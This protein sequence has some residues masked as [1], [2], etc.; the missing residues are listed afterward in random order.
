M[1]S[2]MLIKTKVVEFMI[3]FTKNEYEYNSETDSPI[4][5][6]A[7]LSGIIAMLKGHY[8]ITIEKFKKKRSKNANAYMWQ[9]CNKIAQALSKDGEYIYTKEE[10]YRKAIREVGKFKD[11]PFAEVDKTL[12]YG[13]SKIG[14]GYFTEELEVGYRMYY[15]SSSYDVPQ[16]SRLIDYV[17]QDAKALGIETMTPEELSKLKAEWE[18]RYVR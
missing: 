10:I 16:M 9:L 17:V 3:E 11:Y 13:W 4:K 8:V 7:F 1:F 18:T 12:A 5:F 14:I 6:V 2:C 15:G